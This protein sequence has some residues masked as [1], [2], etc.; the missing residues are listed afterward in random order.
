MPR[1]HNVS[2]NLIAGRQEHVPS[3]MRPL[4]HEAEVPRE[5]VHFWDAS[6]HS[7]RQEGDAPSQTEFLEQSPRKT[8]LGRPPYGS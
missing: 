8:H 3:L 5:D 4:S 6:E 7:L 2:L 1:T